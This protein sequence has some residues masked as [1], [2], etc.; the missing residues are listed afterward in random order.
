MRILSKKEMKAV[1]GGASYC[2][3][4]PYDLYG[5]IPV[6]T[7]PTQPGSGGPA[8]VCVSWMPDYS[9]AITGGGGYHSKCVA[10]K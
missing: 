8:P 9:N 3:Q 6:P 2:G 7:K 10:W 5:C 1:S 4:G